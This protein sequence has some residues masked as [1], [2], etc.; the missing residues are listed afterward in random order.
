[1]TDGQAESGPLAGVFGGEKGVEY[2]GEIVFGDA[3]AG[4][5]NAEECTPVAGRTGGYGQPAALGHGV[6]S[7]AHEMQQNLSEQGRFGVDAGHGRCFLLYFHVFLGGVPAAQGEGV[8]YQGAQVH[9]ANGAFGP[10][11]KDQQLVGDF[12]ASGGLER[13]LAQG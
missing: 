5:L 6:Q 4:V 3:E 11:A 7:V 9:I 13:D 12:P 10:A 8:R 2:S 1:M